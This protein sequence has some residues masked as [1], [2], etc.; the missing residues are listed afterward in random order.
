LTKDSLAAFDALAADKA[1]DE[2]ANN[3]WRIARRPYG[4]VVPED[5]A[6]AASDIPEP[7]PGEA[8]LRVHYLGLA[9][10]MRMYMTG[11]SPSGEVPLNIGDVIHGRGVA[12]IV[13]SRNP[14]WQEGEMVQG[15]C[16]WQTYKVTAFTPQEK[17]FRMPRNG[18][19]AALGAGVLGMTGLS[20]YAGL[21]PTADART[22]D[23]F[24]LSGAAGGVG[25]MV[26]QIAANILSCDVV[27]IAGGAEKC[28]FILDHGCRAAIDYKSDDVAAQIDALMP[29]G[30]DVYFDNVGGETLIAALERLRMGARIV[31]CG[32]I[33]EYLRDP[34][35]ALPN[36]TRLRATDSR[37]AG[38]F[39]YNHIHRW[40]Q[41]MGDLAGWIHDGS[42]KPVQDVTQG[43]EY[44]PRALA[45]LY[46]GRN[47]GVQCCSVRGEPSEW[48]R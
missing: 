40:E 18:L 11:A 38:F 21:F 47:V 44:M 37:M 2:G 35:F 28:A 9:P 27:G 10:V 8:L 48:G 34:P 13:K 26:S 41:V 7:G 30:I 29:G 25:S 5:F 3:Q 42:L 14:N 19:P 45:N 33:S 15:Q 20:A 46:H 22:G 23:Q 31:L 17:F 39:V 1:I 43:F 6:W 32:S 4:N 24:L 16:G 12:Q 36:Y